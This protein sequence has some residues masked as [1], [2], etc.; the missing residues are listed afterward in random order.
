MT[1]V[2]VAE[3][4]DLWR[5]KNLAAK[6]ELHPCLA[7]VEFAEY[8]QAFGYRNLVDAYHDH[9]RCVVAALEYAISAAADLA[10]LLDLPGATSRAPHILRDKLELRSAQVGSG[11]REIDFQEVQSFR[12]VE[13][14]LTD[15]PGA[16]LKPVNRQASLGV[17][18]LEPGDDVRAAWQAAITCLA[19][20]APGDMPKADHLVMTARAGRIATT[21]SLCGMLCLVASATAT[22][23]N[24]PALAL[25]TT[26]IL[27]GIIHQI[28]TNTSHRP[29][30]QTTLAS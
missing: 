14:F 16:V 21:G 4:P 10:E 8:Q 17:H 2:V 11:L 9:V 1:G 29:T 20:V 18:L 6:A 27:A 24:A 5:N 3:E 19:T 22:P 25:T 12:D 23:A 26:L 7:G 15:H 28:L 13:A 30:T